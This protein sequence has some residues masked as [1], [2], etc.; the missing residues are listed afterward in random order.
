MSRSS[1]WRRGLRISKTMLYYTLMRR[2]GGFLAD[3]TR[4]KK[5][6]SQ[7]ID[8][9][10]NVGD[11]K[12]LASDV[13][14]S[15]FLLT[16]MIRDFV[17]GHYDIEIR[18][19]LM[20]LGAVL[21]FLTPADVIPDVVPVLG[22][23]DDASLLAWLFYTLKDELNMYITWRRVQ[24]D[25]VDKVTYDEVYELA[26]AREIEGRSSLDKRALIQAIRERELNAR[27]N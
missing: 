1:E 17:H 20:I 2:A 4:L 16:D 11:K 9:L 22:F 5:L 27:H 13:L 14:A 7:T 15:F 10:K 3:P 19:M 12:A 21:Y 25:S 6:L 26:Q 18:K 8:K 24:N 23:L